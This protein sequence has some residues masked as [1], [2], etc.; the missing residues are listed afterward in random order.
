[1]KIAQICPPW[2]A[3]PPKGY[4]GIEWVVALL[5]DGLTELGHDVTLFAPGGS[6]TKAKLIS[7]FEEP[8]GGTK[9]G[10][11]WYEVIQAASAYKY[12]SDFDIIHDHCGM[13]GPPIGANISKPIVHT[14]HGPFTDMAKRMYRLLAPP[15]KAM[16][17]NATERRVPNPLNLVAISEAQR[18]FCPDLNYAGTVYNGI[19]L[20]LYPFK[21]EK[22]DYLLFLGRVNKEKGPEIAVDIAKAAGMKL[23]MAVKM[24]EAFEQEYW[25]DVVEPRLSGNEE[26]IGEISIEEK[27]S[28][29]ANARATLFP[30]QWPEPF[31]LVMTESMAAGTPVL[32]FPYGAAP[33]VIADGTTGFLCKDFDDMVDA[34]V[35]RVNDIDPAVC[36]AH[37]EKKFGARTM[38]EGYQD[39]YEKVLQR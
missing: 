5:A 3:V 27:A 33:E 17:P 25:R 21:A 34:A 26:I 28:L 23:K 7:E 4:G 2:F 11:F 20:D 35:S 37:V 15:P 32:A 12:A 36:R 22:Q 38:C 1:M 39:V 19:N 14:L 6:V 31:G 30:I 29:I 24:S 13:I 8:P 9:L 18:S 16:G 10:Q